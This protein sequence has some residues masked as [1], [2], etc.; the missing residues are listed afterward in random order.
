MPVISF[1]LNFKRNKG[2]A[3]KQQ[4]GKA[5]VS[6]RDFITLAWKGALLT[7]GFLGLGGLL[8]YLDYQDEP[9]RQVK[10]DL[11]PA[12]NYPPGSR[13]PISQAQ[14]ILFHTAGGFQA[15]STSCPHLGCT[16][17]LTKDGF[18]CP[19]HG[20]R[21]DPQGGLITGPATLGLQVLHVEQTSDGHL[22]LSIE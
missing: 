8:R 7:C 17:E 6:R 3:A 5:V 12:G 9:T 19:C 13:T 22:I 14:A 20:S 16:V 18:T 21:F 1:N 15:L 11:G 2:L 4:L 10:F